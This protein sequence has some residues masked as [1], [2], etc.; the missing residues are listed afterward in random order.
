MELKSRL[1]FLDT[2]IYEGKN[3][4]FLEHSLGS[5]KKLIDD[6]EVHL[7]ITEITKREVV[8]H[9]AK[10]VKYSAAQINKIKK[11]AM[12]FRNVPNERIHA[13]FEKLSVS[14]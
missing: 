7:L 1:V 12:I 3:F 2:N 11:S 5:L 9:I 4:Q 6:A 14:D 8:S 13:I 10:N